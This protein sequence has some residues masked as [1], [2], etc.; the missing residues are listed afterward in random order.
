MFLFYNYLL[1]PNIM[2]SSV[3]NSLLLPPP[4]DLFNSHRLRQVAR[5]IH[6]QPAHR[7]H[8]VGQQLM[9]HGVEQWPQMRCSHR[10]TQ[11]I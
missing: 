11:H 9:R 10:Q 2:G 1:Y 3:D 5:L 4:V 7:R 6:I 8:M